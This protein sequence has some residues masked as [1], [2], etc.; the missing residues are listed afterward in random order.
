MPIKRIFFNWM[1]EKEKKIAMKVF[2]LFRCCWIKVNLILN[3][4]DI[5]W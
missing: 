2:N 4:I 3:F 1:E 5:I